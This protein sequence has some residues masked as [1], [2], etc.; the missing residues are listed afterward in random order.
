M[1]G[2]TKNV[3]VRYAGESIIRRLLEQTSQRVERFSAYSE[4]RDGTSV[5]SL[6]FEIAQNLPRFFEDALCFLDDA[7]ALRA[8]GRATCDLRCGRSRF[9]FR[10]LTIT[11]RISFGGCPS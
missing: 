6:C 8:S 10:Q 5:I 4:S 2:F 3:F 7:E 9:R 11:I 1:F